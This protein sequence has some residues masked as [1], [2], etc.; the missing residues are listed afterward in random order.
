MRLAVYNVENLFDRPRVMNQ[1]T[2]EQGKEIL[3]DYAELARLLGEAEYPPAVRLRMV[4]LMTRLGL[5][6]KDEGRFVLLRRNRG[7]LLRRSE[8]VGLEIIADGR[9]DWSGTLELVEEPVD[10]V[11]MRLTARVIRDLGADVLAVVEAESRPVLAQFNQRIVAAEGGRPMAHVMV[12][13]GNDSRG[14]DVG[15]MTGPAYPIDLMR[16]H[17]DDRDARGE[18]IFSRDCPE[19][20]IALPG[21]GSM[22]VLVNHF[23]S[24]GYGTPAASARKRAAQAQRVREIYEARI[25]QGDALVAVVGDLND[26]PTSKALAPLLGHTDLRDAFDHPAFDRGGHAGTHG[27]CKA[28]DRIDHLLLSPALHARVERGGVIRRGMWPGSR[29]ARWEVYP[30]LDDPRHAASDHAALWVDLAV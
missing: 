9:A 21:G 1:G 14:I 13:D 19:Y 8:P 2:W 20:R 27:P 22:W 11:A 17:V 30:E 6:K 16:S 29:P 12:I 18:A 15:L 3:Q 7:N 4:E 24:K 10:A 5:A 26:T 28:A 23:K 25:A